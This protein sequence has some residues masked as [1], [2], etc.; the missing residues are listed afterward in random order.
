M[1]TPETA[2]VKIDWSV[3]PER[4][5]TG[6]TVS[7]WVEKARVLQKRIVLCEADDPRVLA[8][9]LLAQKHG[10]ART[11]LLA[12]STDVLE[13]ARGVGWA[14]ELPAGLECIDPA[15]AA[16]LPA[17]ADLLYRKRQSKGMTREQAKELARQPLMF[18]NL[19]VASGQAD[20]CVSGAAHT[21]A[22]V[23]R[24]A[25]QVIGK[26]P[27]ARLVSSFFVMMPAAGKPGSDG[28]IFTDCGLVIEPTA[29]ELAQIALDGASSAM[30]ILGQEARI[31]MLSFATAGSAK[32][33]L[34]DKVHEATERVRALAPG[35]KVDGEVQ[36]DAAL[37]PAIAARK[38]PQ[39]Q[40]H[41]AAN[42][43]V[44]PNL[45]AGNIGYKLVERLG[46]AMAIG[47]LLQGLARPANDLS[48]GCDATDV[49]SVI[50]LTALQAQ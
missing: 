16:Q 40:I 1:K 31:A 37:V 2:P 36:A 4:L 6:G 8:A 50:T 9:A 29:E 26:R 47:P 34:V 5:R 14:G 33:A 25:L 17:L 20:G 42:V 23:V 15:R 35:L 21:T 7:A 32:H 3:L 28:L 19:S 41:G 13:R 38:L 10:I 24:T 39:S 49:L 22:D 30:R 18:A 46:G 44:F 12:S 43:L 45:D 27:D 48:R 11:V